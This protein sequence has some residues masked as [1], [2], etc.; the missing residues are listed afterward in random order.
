MKAITPV[1]MRSLRSRSA[2]ISPSS[3]IWTIFSSIVCPIPVRLFALPSSAIC[4]I[5]AGVSRMSVAAR[6]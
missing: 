5:D 1:G 6:R 4:A 2:W 3:T